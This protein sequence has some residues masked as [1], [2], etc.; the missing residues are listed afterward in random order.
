MHLLLRPRVDRMGKE[1]ITCARAVKSTSRTVG[2]IHGRMRKMWKNWE[3]RG[4]CRQGT[5]RVRTRE[6]GKEA[7][8]TMCSSIGKMCRDGEGDR[9]RRK[10]GKMA[11]RVI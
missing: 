9:A 2:L 4:L 6:V 1:R 3:G 5:E 10:E 7:G 8:L 11:N